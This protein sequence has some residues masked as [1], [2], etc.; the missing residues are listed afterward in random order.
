L[1][2]GPIF[3]PLRTECSPRSF[4]ALS[5]ATTL[6]TAGILLDQSA[7]TLRHGLE[8]IARPPGDAAP[9]GTFDSDHRRVW[10]L[11]RIDEL[12]E[13]RR[14]GPHLTAPWQVVFAGRPNAGKSSLINALVGYARSIVD[15][16]P[17]TTRDIV[18]EQTAFEGWPVE[19][20][21]TAGLREGAGNVEA[22]GIARARERLARAECRVIVIDQGEPPDPEAVALVRAWPEALVVAHKSDLPDQ[23]GATMPT[24]ALRVSSLH[25]TGIDEVALAI[26]RRLVPAV[27]PAGMP[28][29]VTERQ[30]ELL[31]GLR[32]A[33]VAN[34]V[35]GAA[36]LF[37][38]LLA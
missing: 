12:L 3:R 9:V 24:E 20:A 31:E 15:S 14:F 19:L 1:C 38:A 16:V 32:A 4:E 29:P 2:R 23:W 30:V 26:T 27:P 17:G 25:R 36:R 21:D 37:G 8:A 34:D 28:I 22:A 10:A 7:G 33:L 5:R 18:T 13:W 6:R 11:A 35:N